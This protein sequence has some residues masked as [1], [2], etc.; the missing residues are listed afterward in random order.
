MLDA[1]IHSGSTDVETTFDQVGGSVTVGLIVSAALTL[2]VALWL[3][4]RDA[5]NAKYVAS[6][7]LASDREQ[8]V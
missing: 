8:H 3:Q 2:T 6:Q 1:A 4:R 5:R 7:R